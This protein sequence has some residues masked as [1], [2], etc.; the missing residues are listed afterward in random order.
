MQFA[1]APQASACNGDKV[2]FEE[3]FTVH[4]HSW[5]DPEPR[6]LEIY[7]AMATARPKPD[8]SYWQW[9]S[10]FAF[11]D[12]DI[13]L[14]VTLIETTDPTK[15]D[16]GL[17]F[18]VRD[19]SNFFVLTIASNGHYKVGRY[20]NG[21]WVDP[22]PVPWTQS[23][24]IK[25][26]PN[27]PNR[28]DLTLKGQS[29]TIAINDKDVASVQADVPAKASF[30]GLYAASGPGKPSTWQLTDLKVTNVK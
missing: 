23:D 26:G 11:L 8:S 15:S 17:L 3:D 30:I 19:N 16:A 25:Q 18:W 7:G 4:D 21:A 20:R 29:A 28:V 12:A 22:P 1:L 5:G 13:C 14:T 10:G 24:A 27:A 9:N 2:L 6:Q